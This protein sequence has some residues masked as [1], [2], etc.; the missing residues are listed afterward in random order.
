MKIR[1]IY[2]STD[3]IR[4]MKTQFCEFTEWEE[5]FSSHVSGKG[6]IHWIY[7][8]APKT[9]QQKPKQFKSRQ[10]PK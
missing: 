10:V 3:T 4:R 2:I 5:I 7:E 1:S 9:Q 8:E 6:S